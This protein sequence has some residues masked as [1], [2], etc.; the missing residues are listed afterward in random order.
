VGD[1]LAAA[2]ADHGHALPVAP[3][4]ADGAGERARG[5]GPAPPRQRQV[6]AAQGAVLQLGG[7]GLVGA[8][9]AGDHQQAAGVAV[10]P[11]D[12]P[13]P[14]G[15]AG[16]GQLQAAVR[17]GVDQGAVG[18]AGRGVDHQAHG[19]GDHQQV[20]V[21]VDHVQGDVL[22]RGGQRLPLRWDVAHLGAGGG[23]EGLR[24]RAPVHQHLA[25]GEGLLE[26]AAREVGGVVGEDAV[27][28]RAGLRGG[29]LQDAAV[30]H[31]PAPPAPAAGPGARGTPPAA[32]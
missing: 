18:M 10:Q 3:V 12:D 20:G 2:P 27:Q 24:A 1:G 16:V 17:Q 29:D 8:R 32:G 9:G 4:A 21:L 30:S 13:R 5:P 19:L 11:V 22:G 23:A 14:Q 15:V 6:D 31:G 7:Q 28:A 25:A 26:L